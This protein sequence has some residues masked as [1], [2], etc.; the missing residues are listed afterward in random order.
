M[1]IFVEGK[2]LENL[3]KNPQLLYDASPRI[4]PKITVLRGKCLATM[5]PM[6]PIKRKATQY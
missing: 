5:P 6:L 1:L 3:E 4:E 2:K